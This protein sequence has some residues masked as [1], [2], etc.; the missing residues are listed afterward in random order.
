MRAWGRCRCGLHAR[1]MRAMR[2][3]RPHARGLDGIKKRT[4]AHFPF[5][6]PFGP[7]I[8]GAQNEREQNTER[9][10]EKAEQNRTEKTEKGAEQ[11]CG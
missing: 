3:T 2:V 1:D 5:S 6:V 11:A 4:S 9:G 10:A 8:G 7:P